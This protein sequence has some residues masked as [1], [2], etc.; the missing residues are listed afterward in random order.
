MRLS[1][2]SATVLAEPG[3]PLP[4]GVWSVGKGGCTP[5]LV[6][7][8]SFA[9]DRAGLGR[10][11]CR[12]AVMTMDP[13][14]LKRL[15]RE[16]MARTGESYT[17][18]RQQLARRELREAVSDPTSAAE[19]CVAAGREIRKR[20]TSMLL[21][22]GD[23]ASTLGIGR[24]KLD[25]IERGVGAIDEALIRRMQTALDLPPATVRLVRAAAASVDADDEA[26]AQS[27]LPDVAGAP[28]IWINCEG[29]PRARTWN[30]WF[31]VD[32]HMV[33]AVEYVEGLDW[34]SAIRRSRTVTVE[35]PT[36]QRYWGEAQIVDRGD[37]ARA[38]AVIAARHP[39]DADL[40]AE[41][42]LVGIAVDT[43]RVP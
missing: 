13:K 12:Q 41:S 17:T 5:G 24:L 10:W 16:R 28:G 34:I 31:A 43:R 19:L 39:A 32:G 25:L 27:L 6:R 29:P 7:E 26:G 2:R 3:R 11:A 40:L 9:A 22:L 14:D 33:F 23:L 42:V 20:R 36:G 30:E 35:L 4:N 1:S 8:A 21:T 15:A 18:A 37:R 38:A